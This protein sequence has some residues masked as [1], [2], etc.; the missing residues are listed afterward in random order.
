MA[1]PNLKEIEWAIEELETQ[2]SSEN[3]YTLL[4]ALYI[5]RNQMMGLSDSVATTVE[6]LG[7]YGDS[8]FLSAVSSK[9]PRETLLIID[10]LMETLKV[11]QPRIYDIVLRKLR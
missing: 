2:E 1:A 4:A 8:D 3:R 11:L 5:C 9:D 6:T 7:Q 10:E